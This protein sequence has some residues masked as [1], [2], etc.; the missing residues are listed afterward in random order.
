[1]SGQASTDAGL[2]AA[3]A[4]FYALMAAIFRRPL[5]AGQVEGLRN[6][7][8]LAALAAA[9]IDPGPDFA[10]APA[11]DLREAL[12]IDFTHIFHD[13]EGKIMPYEGLML[14]GDDE[15]HGKRS[16]EVERFLAS[17]GYRVPPESGE[18]ADH[19]AVEL[20]FMA[21]LA[22]R[23]AGAV[24]GHDHETAERA[25]A[26]QRDFLEQHLGQWLDRLAGQV[27]ARAQ[28]PFYANLARALAEF[29]QSDR[30]ALAGTG[31]A[32]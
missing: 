25:R 29:V 13:P 28:G 17:V 1:M 19:I 24:A 10:S 14:A 31:G 11:R 12:A 21:D 27:A 18:M 26:I 32:R 16:E 15:L 20:E 22:R 8:M 9:G 30:E 6:P 5:D 3:R 4:E 7:Q 23:E 2:I